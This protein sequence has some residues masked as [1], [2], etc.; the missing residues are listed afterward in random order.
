[1]E[2]YTLQ[3]KKIDCPS[4]S[5]FNGLVLYTVDSEQAAQHFVLNEVDLDR[6]RRLRG[7]IE[8]LWAQSMCDI[9]RCTGC[10]FCFADPFVAGDARFYDLAY[11]RSSYPQW[12]WEYERTRE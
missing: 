8:A 4:C 7:H 3:P 5:S 12:K 6:H 10:G 1:M 9:V 11:Q 2:K